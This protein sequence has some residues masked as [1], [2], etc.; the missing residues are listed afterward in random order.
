MEVRKEIRQAVSA[1]A[2]AVRKTSDL[3]RYGESDARAYYHAVEYYDQMKEM[4]LQQLLTDFD[5]MEERL[6]VLRNSDLC[7]LADDLLAMDE[8]W[9]KD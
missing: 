9:N 7:E 5:T 4:L 2:N 1:L 6:S 8:E 3:F